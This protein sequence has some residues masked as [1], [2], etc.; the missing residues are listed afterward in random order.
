[1][2]SVA[3]TIRLASD[4]KVKCD[5]TVRSDEYGN[6]TW[7]RL[8]WSI[9]GLRFGPMGGVKSET[10][11]GGW[12]YYAPYRELY[13]MTGDEHYIFGTAWD[14]PSSFMTD[15]TCGRSLGRDGDFW[16]NGGYRETSW[17]FWYG[18]A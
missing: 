5:V 11:S 1:M 15:A 4:S 13:L 18:C 3:L 10:K 9:G 14:V 17:T 8:G 7:S 16:H 2:P 6:R 12:V